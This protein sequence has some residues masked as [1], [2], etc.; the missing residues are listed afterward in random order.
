MPDAAASRAYSRKSRGSRPSARCTP[1]VSEALRPSR[2]S[3]NRSVRSVTK[4]GGRPSCSSARR[5]LLGGDRHVADV[6]SR[7]RADLGRGIREG[8]QPRPG[9]LVPLPDVAIVGQRGDGDVGDVVGVDERLGHVPGRERELAVVDGLEQ[10]PLAE[11]LAEP[12]STARSSTRRRSCST[13]CSA[14]CAPSSFRPES[15]TRRRTPPSTARRVNAADAI[16][17][18]GKREVGRRSSRTPHRRR[19]SAASQVSGRSQSNDGSAARDPMRTARSRAR[20]RSATRRPVLPVPPTT[21]VDV[22][23]FVRSVMLRSETPE[24]ETIH[25]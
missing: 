1:S 10:E 17:G 8:E 22:E 23:V 3:R 19:R 20:N 25:S 2:I 14:R 24:P 16:G 6:P 4:S 12:C 7:R 5:E 18:A 9:H 15:R 21:R 11:V 13:A